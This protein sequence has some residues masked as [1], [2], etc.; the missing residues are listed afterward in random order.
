MFLEMLINGNGEL[1]GLGGK[2]PQSDSLVPVFIIFDS[3]F[4]ILSPVLPKITSS[5]TWG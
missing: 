1:C 4:E 5:I 2:V 3:R